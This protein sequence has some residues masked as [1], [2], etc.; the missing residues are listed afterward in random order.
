M[1]FAVITYFLSAHLFLEFEIHDTYTLQ[2]FTF[3]MQLRFDEIS[4][5]F[6]STFRLPVLKSRIKFF[7]FLS[8]EYFLGVDRLIK[9]CTSTFCYIFASSAW[10]FCQQAVSFLLQCVERQKVRDMSH[11]GIFLSHHSLLFFFCFP[12]HTAAILFNFLVPLFTF[13]SVHK[14]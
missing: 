14:E 1:R 13:S 8:F 4:T 5:L 2:L 6:I 3:C 10:L 9:L 11:C 12:Y 7:F